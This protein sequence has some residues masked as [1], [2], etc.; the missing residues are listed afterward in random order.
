MSHKYISNEA[1]EFINDWEIGEVISM[2][3]DLNDQESDHFAVTMQ[4]EYLT[5]H[6]NGVIITQGESEVID[7]LKQL[8]R[9]LCLF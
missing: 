5:L 8:K 1:L 6:I 2:I 9:E 7:R 3:D 4:D